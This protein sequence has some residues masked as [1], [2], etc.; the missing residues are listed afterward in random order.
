MPRIGDLT[1]ARSNCAHVPGERRSHR[2]WWAVWLLMLLAAVIPA[3]LVEDL[4]KQWWWWLIVAA[5][6]GWR[7][8][9]Q[10]RDVLD[11]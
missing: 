11:K 8:L 9:N 5:I 6:W 10:L 7:I 4:A 3:V 1:R 2:A